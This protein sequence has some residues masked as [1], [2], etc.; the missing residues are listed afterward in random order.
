MTKILNSN[1][2]S[3]LNVESCTD[4]TLTGCD[5][6]LVTL[7]GEKELINIKKLSQIYTNPHFTGPDLAL[8]ILLGVCNLRFKTSK[9]KSHRIS[10]IIVNADFQKREKTFISDFFFLQ[11]SICP[12]LLCFGPVWPTW[13]CFWKRG[14]RVVL[15][16]GK[17]FTVEPCRSKANQKRVR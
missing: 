1:N 13:P 6:F 17:P 14:R 9:T 4:L 3:K 15:V 11:L 16:V 7:T 5:Y 8:L 12:S 10:I 2:K